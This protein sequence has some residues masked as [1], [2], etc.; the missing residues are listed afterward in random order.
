MAV[1]PTA[2]SDPSYVGRKYVYAFKE[3]GARSVEI[4]DIRDRR[5][6]SDDRFLRLVRGCDLVF[7]TGGD[8]EKLVNT[9]HGTKVYEA[10][11]EKYNNG[12]TVAGT[13]AGAAAACDPILFDGDDRGYVK[14]SVRHSMGFDLVKDVT[15]DTHFL[16]RNRMFRLIQYIIT[17]NKRLG[18]GL[19]EDT[20]IVVCPDEK[21]FVIG[22]SYV[23]LVKA[24]KLKYSNYEK[25]EDGDILAI[26]GI[27]V[28]YLS[29]NYGYNLKTHKVISPKYKIEKYLNKIKEREFERFSGK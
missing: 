28:S 9:L 3:L 21:F 17:H 5:D 11:M 8:Q 13:S 27:H 20:G 24:D 15:I 2:S 19:A 14:G 23:T 16:R 4:L 29:E 26:D 25:I 1:I 22:S 7:F 12:V 18:I 6:S 10:I